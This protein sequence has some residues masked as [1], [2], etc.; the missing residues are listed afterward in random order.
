MA[1]AEGFL[2]SFSRTDLIEIV[3]V[4]FKREDRKVNQVPLSESF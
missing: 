1:D 4:Y 2:D 3:S